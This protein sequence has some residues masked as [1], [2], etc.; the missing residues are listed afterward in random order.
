MLAPVLAPAE[1]WR[2]SGR[3][4]IPEVFRLTDRHGRDFVLS[5]THEETMTFHAREL[6]SYRQLPQLWYHF[7][8][9]GRDEVRPRAACCECASS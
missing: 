9:K 5:M 3:Y 4:D 1:L 2:E 6:G 8:V 7:Q